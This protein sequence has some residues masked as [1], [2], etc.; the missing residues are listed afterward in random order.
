MDQEGILA[1]GMEC[2]YSIAQQPGDDA[3]VDSGPFRGDAAGDVS[4]TLDTGSSAGTIVVDV[5]PAR[6]ER[7]ALLKIKMMLADG[8]L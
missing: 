1:S 5:A 4:T 8:W 7:S 2:A 6:L 3:D